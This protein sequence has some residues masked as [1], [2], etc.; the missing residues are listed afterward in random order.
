MIASAWHGLLCVVEAV[1]LVF[2]IVALGLDLWRTSK[3][4]RR[5]GHD[6]D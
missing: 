5:A 4:F 3:D 2:A 6:E 1:F